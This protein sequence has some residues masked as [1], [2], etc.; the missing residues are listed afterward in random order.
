MPRGL[1]TASAAAAAAAGVSGLGNQ[2][3]VLLVVTG[4]SSGGQ[5]VSTASGTRFV[6]S[7]G[8]LGTNSPP[9]TVVER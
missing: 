7:L 1:A 3:S 9:D 5:R 2:G 4:I 6:T 8:G